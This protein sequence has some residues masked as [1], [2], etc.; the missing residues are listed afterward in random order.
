[1]ENRWTKKTQNGDGMVPRLGSSLYFILAYPLNLE[2]V[3][4][5]IGIL[6]KRPWKSLIFHELYH[7]RCPF[8]TQLFYAVHFLGLPHLSVSSRPFKIFS[9]QNKAEAFS[10]HSEYPSGFL[11]RKKKL[12]IKM[13]YTLRSV[14]T[15]QPLEAMVVWKPWWFPIGFRGTFHV[16]FGVQGAAGRTMTPA[17]CSRRHSLKSA[18]WKDNANVPDRGLRCKGNHP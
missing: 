13:I 2:N 9:P 14:L 11:R 12:Q 16:R 6:F 8:S 3:E 1:M 17:V 4:S 15:A 5:F 7:W 10:T 18:G